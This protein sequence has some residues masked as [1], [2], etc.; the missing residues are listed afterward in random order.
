VVLRGRGV[1]GRQGRKRGNK[2][3]IVREKV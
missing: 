2:S 1:M 3:I